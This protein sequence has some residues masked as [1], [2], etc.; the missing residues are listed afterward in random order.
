MTGGFDLNENRTEMSEKIEVPV[1]INK[2][3]RKELVDITYAHGKD[4]F[5]EKDK[6]DWF[7]ILCGIIAIACLAYSAYNVY[8]NGPDV[9]FCILM[10]IYAI[11]AIFCFS[12]H[13][14]ISL[15][16]SSWRRRLKGRI[17]YGKKG[18]TVAFDEESVAFT[19][20]GKI[21]VCPYETVWDAYET[22][23]YFIIHVS[24][25]CIIPVSKSVIVG[26]EQDG[27]KDLIA[28]FG[29]LVENMAA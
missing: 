9:I 10:G 1:S 16:R 6:I 3:Q 12:K 18:G 28:Y 13:L 20:R 23:E 22:N 29:T 11:V 8:M 26:L 14:Q 24:D 5:T 25:R 4:T 7:V 17:V 19:Y 27:R 21:K 15:N 2:K